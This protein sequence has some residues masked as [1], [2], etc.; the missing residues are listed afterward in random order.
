MATKQIDEAIQ[1][2]G[3]KAT[4]YVTDYKGVITSISVDLYGCIQALVVPGLDKEGKI[5]GGAWLD[6]NRLKIS[7]DKRVMDCPHLE[8]PKGPAD[9][10]V[11]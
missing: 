11:F 3:K 6:L 1:L 2:L 5:P 7:N 4:D 10:P 9:K 8:T